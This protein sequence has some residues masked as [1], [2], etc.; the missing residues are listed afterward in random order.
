MVP[1]LIIW[2]LAVFK[3]HLLGASFDV[4]LLLVVSVV[5]VL[6]YSRSAMLSIALVYLSLYIRCFISGKYNLLKLSF[7]V[8]SPFT[9]LAFIASYYDLIIN[10]EAVARIDERGLDS[11]RYAFWL[12]YLIEQDLKSILFGSNTY[13]VWEQLDTLFFKDN[14]R[15]TL[16]NSFLQLHIHG[17]IIAVLFSLVM[18]LKLFRAAKGYEYIVM[19]SVLFV[20][21][22][23]IFFDT[24]LFPQRFDFLFFALYFVI[25]QQSR[26]KA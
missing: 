21:M 22:S 18:M 4:K 20:V 10:N 2:L 24:V 5:S 8:L 11:G 9:A 17:G 23:K 13:E 6:S 19:L 1:I 25:A 26:A 15:H 14:G 7:L 16:H 3:N 12:W